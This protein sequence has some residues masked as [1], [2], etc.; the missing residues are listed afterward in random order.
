MVL[1]LRQV[2][3]AELL[4]VVARL[5]SRF[6]GSKDTA[7][8]GIGALQHSTTSRLDPGNQRPGYTMHKEYSTRELET[9][10]HCAQGSV[11]VVAGTREPQTARAE[12]ALKA[13]DA[14]LNRYG[15]HY[16]VEN[17]KAQLGMR[18][19]VLA[20]ERSSWLTAGESTTAS[21]GTIIFAKDTNCNVSGGRRWQHGSQEA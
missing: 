19:V 15:V 10:V 13:L 4:G 16:A 11:V 20:Q 9:D 17:P 12:T 7:D 3:A 8:M 5:A 18:P 1:D 14:A 21:T 2:T 6:A